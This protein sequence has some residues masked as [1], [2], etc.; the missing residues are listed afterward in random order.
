MSL[1]L[2][3]TLLLDRVPT[4]PYCPPSAYCS[5]LLLAWSLKAWSYNQNLEQLHVEGER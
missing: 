4:T 1:G 5:G 3:S 2:A